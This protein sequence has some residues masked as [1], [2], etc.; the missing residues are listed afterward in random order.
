M[1]LS[2]IENVIASY[3]DPN[4]RAYLKDAIARSVTNPKCLTIAESIQD[5]IQKALC[6][7]AN[8]EETHFQY[9]E[10]ADVLI[11]PDVHGRLDLFLQNLFI[12]KLI[13]VQG[14][15]CGEERTVI[16]LGDLISRGAYSIE[17]LIY[18]RV[19]QEQCQRV[20]GKFI[21]LFGNHEHCAVNRIK[22]DFYNVRDYEKMAKIIEE[23][24]CQGHTTLVYAEE[25]RNFICVHAGIE[26]EILV[27]CLCA[28]RPCL[29][30]QILPDKKISSKEIATMMIEHRVGLNE[31]MHYMNQIFVTD[32]SIDAW[33]LQDNNARQAPSGVIYTRKKLGEKDLQD[34]AKDK[35]YKFNQ[36][37]GHTTTDHPDNLKFATSFGAVK[38]I[39]HRFFLDYDLL[40]GKQAFVALNGREVVQVRSKHSGRVNV[41]PTLEKDL[42]IPECLQQNPGCHPGNLAKIK[43]SEWEEKVIARLP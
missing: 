10:G 24:I 41:Q 14:N 3:R 13:D 9:L 5:I 6:L 7:E 15:W 23:H 38:K 19:L 26:K 43:F 22:L 12:A 4:V 17:T 34:I 40:R 8:G 18:V 11:F 20:G 37:V 21:V 42:S 29:N 1:C 39:N 36:F 32:L 28:L 16:Q 33:L 25:E 2:D 35:P 27:K 31:L 30:K